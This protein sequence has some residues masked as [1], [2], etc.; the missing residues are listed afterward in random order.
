MNRPPPSASENTAFHQA[1]GKKEAESR[2][3]PSLVDAVRDEALYTQ[4]GE[5]DMVKAVEGL[6]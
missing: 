2:V 5:A 4:P 3:R 6:G 1:I